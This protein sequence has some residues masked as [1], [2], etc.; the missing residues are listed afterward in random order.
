MDDVAWA[1]FRDEL[2]KLAALTPEEQSE[3][4]AAIRQQAKFDQI[5]DMDEATAA[6]HRA[7]TERIKTYRAKSQGQQAGIPTWA[8]ETDG[9]PPEQPSRTY[10]AGGGNPYKHVP[11][12]MVGRY[13][14]SNAAVGAQLGAAGGALS[15]LSQALDS[16]RERD[17]KREEGGPVGRFMYDHPIVG[18]A[19]TG[20]AIFG[21]KPVALK[22]L[23]PGLPSV[24]APYVAV[25]G[26][27]VG[28]NKI[29]EMREQAA[30]EEAA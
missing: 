16:E 3:L 15:S 27:L 14:L 18:G 29:L 24:L 19:A 8:K 28:L 9:V 26:S 17:L 4:A 21:L 6:A 13:A 11:W 2:T 12:G 20:G 5:K 30:Q 25:G 1:A 7:N 10:V 23:G 22:V